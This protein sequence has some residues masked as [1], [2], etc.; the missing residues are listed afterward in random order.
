MPC[1]SKEKGPTY[2]KGGK[3]SRVEGLEIRVAEKV[4]P[5]SNSRQVLMLSF[6]IRGVCN[7]EP[8]GVEETF[9]GT[10]ITRQRT[11]KGKWTGFLN[12]GGCCEAE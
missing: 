2:N 10:V 9:A 11:G 5:L 7:L 6:V 1:R 4:A 12:D 3:A 8:R